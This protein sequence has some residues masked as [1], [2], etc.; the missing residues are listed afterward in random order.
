[1]KQ[2]YDR[3]IER[4]EFEPGDQVL[5]LRPIIYFPFESKFDGPF[6]VQHKLSDEN[7]EVITSSQKNSVKR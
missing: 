1:M 5:V 3:T 4:R 6:F 7:Y 2:L